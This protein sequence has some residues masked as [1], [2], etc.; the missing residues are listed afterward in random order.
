[1]KMIMQRTNVKLPNAPIVRPIIEISKFN[2]GHD[3]A[4]LKTRSWYFENINFDFTYGIFIQ[5]D[6][7]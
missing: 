5:I 6:L 3:L 2:V 1:M 7:K 4:S